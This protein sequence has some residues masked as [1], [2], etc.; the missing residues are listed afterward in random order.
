MILQLDVDG[1]GGSHCLCA[2]EIP[3]SAKLLSCRSWWNG[4]WR[5]VVLEIGHVEDQGVGEVEELECFTADL[6]AGLSQR[7]AAGLGDVLGWLLWALHL[8]NLPF[9]EVEHNLLPFV[10]EHNC[11]DLSGE[12]SGVSEMGV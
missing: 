9:G 5:Y 2:Y 10:M 4:N 8:G 6:L 1:L 7:V 12:M 11:V 3:P